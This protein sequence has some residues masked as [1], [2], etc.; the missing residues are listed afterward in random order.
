MYE[1]RENYRLTYK[2]NGEEYLTITIRLISFVV[3][4]SR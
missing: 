2:T 3:V 1:K 4:F